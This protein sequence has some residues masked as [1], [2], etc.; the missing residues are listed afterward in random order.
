MS[1]PPL[2]LAPP[3]HSK[4]KELREELEQSGLKPGTPAYQKK[5]NARHVDI[6]QELRRTQ[7]S[8]CS[9]NPCQVLT[10]HLNDLQGGN[11]GQFPF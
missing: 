6:C 5:Y 11:G 4:L 9:L 3:E 1:K 10:N 2:H 7:C 8:R